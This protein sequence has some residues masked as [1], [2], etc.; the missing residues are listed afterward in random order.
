MDNSQTSISPIINNKY[1][2]IIVIVAIIIIFVSMQRDPN[3]CGNCNNS[4]KEYFL[5][6]TDKTCNEIEAD[7]L[8]FGNCTSCYNFGYCIETIKYNEKNIDT[9]GTC[10]AGDIYGPYDK[11]ECTKWYHI[12]PYSYIIHKNIHNQD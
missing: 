3:E 7:K 4:N 1:K 8:N 12:D 5:G 9:I 2:L 10:K 11:T 6:H